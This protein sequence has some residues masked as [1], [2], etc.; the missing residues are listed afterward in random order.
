MREEV[1]WALATP[2]PCA[3]GG[4]ID[5]QVIDKQVSALKEKRCSML[6]AASLINT[7]PWLSPL[8]T[9][10]QMTTVGVIRALG[11]TVSEIITG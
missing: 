6:E 10:F 5:K 7:Q 1:R 8:P 9:G 3:A 4:V 2:L 11:S